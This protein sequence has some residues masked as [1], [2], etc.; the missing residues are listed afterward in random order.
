MYK[1]YICGMF[2]PMATNV[3]VKRSGIENTSGIIRRFTKKVQGSGVL[4]RVRKI[5]F[6][7]RNPS[8]FLRKKHALKSIKARK[9]YEEQSKLGT[10][11]DRKKRGHR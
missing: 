8:K 3:T 7:K 11:K 1:E 9:I 5:R 4:R 2:S 6:H 10:L